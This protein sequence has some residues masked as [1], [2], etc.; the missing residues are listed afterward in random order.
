MRSLC[1]GGVDV[2]GRSVP[3]RIRA[4]FVLSE[5]I[6]A[7]RGARGSRSR[8]PTSVQEDFGRTG[9]GR[10]ALQGEAVQPKPSQC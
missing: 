9:G 10:T 8:R 6:S 7:P 4:G 2:D 1:M 5:V 3:S